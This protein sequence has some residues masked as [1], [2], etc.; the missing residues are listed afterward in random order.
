MEHNFVWHKG[1]RNLEH[2][3]FIKEL[4]DVTDHHVEKTFGHGA[5][6]KG[7][8]KEKYSKSIVV[9]DRKQGHSYTLYKSYGAWRVG[10]YK[11]HYKH[12]KLPDG[13]HAHSPNVDELHQHILNKGSQKVAEDVVVESHTFMRIKNILK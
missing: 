3:S 11:N 4:P 12:I 7:Q 10:G 5:G 2:S 1:I 6:M 8:N 9:H 13:V